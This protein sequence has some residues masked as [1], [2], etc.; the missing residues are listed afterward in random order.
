[1][2]EKFWEFINNHWVFSQ[3]EKDINSMTGLLY[4]MNRRHNYTIKVDYEGAYL[5][6][7]CL[8]EDYVEFVN[9]KQEEN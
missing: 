4:E 3:R 9:G 2:N 1:M 6:L 8:F 7:L 5:D